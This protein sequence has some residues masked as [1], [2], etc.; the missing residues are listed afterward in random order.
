MRGVCVL[1]SGMRRVY[2]RQVRTRECYV[3]KVYKILGK[4][5]RITI[6]QEL[7][8]RM[9]L[10]GGDIVSFEMTEDRLVLK[11]EKLYTTF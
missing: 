4:K 3:M 5:G 6:P 9:W 7:R 2:G 1:L 8:T 10:S 11:K